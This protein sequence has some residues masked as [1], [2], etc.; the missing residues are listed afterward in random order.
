MA[1][2]QHPDL[3][4]TEQVLS[5]PGGMKSDHP[6]TGIGGVWAWRLGVEAAERIQVRDE[7]G[8]GGRAA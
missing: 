6:A 4:G 2:L 1:C 3:P 8:A 7:A 5:H